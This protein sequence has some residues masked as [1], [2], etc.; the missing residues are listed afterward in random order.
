[1]V[2]DD[3]CG[4]IG[5]MS[6]RVNR[7]TTGKPVAVSLGTPQISHDLIWVRIRAA[8]VRSHRL[9]AWAIARL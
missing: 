6:G 3:E 4:T 2:V 9:P 5:G 7:S 1:M 8:A